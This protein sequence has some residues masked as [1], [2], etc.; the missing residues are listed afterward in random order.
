MIQSDKF[1][2]SN[3]DIKKI[4]NL[5]FLFLINRLIEIFG[6]LVSI[7]GIVLLISLISYSPDDPNFIFPE[8]TEIQNLLGFRGSYMSDFFLQ[9]VGFIAYLI[10]ITYIFMGINLELVD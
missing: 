5:T 4:A 7:V 2:L 8:T 1:D 3:M 10:P 9:S 6:I